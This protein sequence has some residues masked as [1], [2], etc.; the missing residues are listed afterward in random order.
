[1][2][3][4]KMMGSVLLVAGLAACGGGGGSPGTTNTSTTTTT[5]T[6]PVTTANSAVSSLLLASDKQQIP[7]D[8]ISPA[9]VVV[10]ALDAG[11]AR[12][13]NAVVNLTL[14]GGGILSTSSVTTGAGGTASFQLTARASDQ[15]NREIVVTASCE[16]CSA[17]ATTQSIKV[18]GASLNV[19]A[20]A[21]T[22]VIGGPP[23][24]IVV[25]VRDV[26]GNTMPDVPV[27]FASTDSSVLA[28]AASS[29]KTNASGVASVVV[30]AQGSGAAS[31]NISGLGEAKSL[32]FTVSS[33]TNALSFT[34]PAANSVA[35][36][37]TPQVIVVS[38]QG[39]SNV[40]FATTLGSFANG[41]SNQTV[42][43]NNGVAQAVLTSPLSGKATINAVDDISRSAALQLTISPPVSAANQIILTA[44][45][46]TIP[47]ST[48]T[49][50]SSI[51]VTARVQSSNGTTGQPV[52]NVPVVFS[53]TGGPN[54]GEY[55]TPALAK[56]DSTGV[57]TATFYAG[58]M[59]SIANGIEISAQIPNTSVETGVS[60]SSNDLL[61]T[62]G[63]QALSVAFGPGTRVQSSSDN[64]LY[65]LPYSVLVTDANN[66]P[67]AGAEV[68]LRMRPF[69][70]STG[71]SC[72]VQKT[73][74]SEDRN[75]NGSLDADEDGWRVLLSNN[76][77][78]ISSSMCS[79]ESVFIVDDK[80]KNLTPQNSD[81]G[82]VPRL[83][84][85]DSQ[86][87]ASFNLTYLKQS[88]LWVVPMLTATVASN[89]TESS[90]STIF[91]LRPSVEDA[92]DTTCFLPPSP[93]RE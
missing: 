52:A 44:I 25:T 93:Y 69:A 11:S 7:A 58:S 89:G 20:S 54:G 91:R 88:A 83:L 53:M 2:K 92:G 62:I 90:R 55:L 26:L 34:E 50:Q 73:F 43:V 28:V 15:T 63:G 12:V 77:S 46:T 39:A 19:T 47:I 65:L 22:L 79:S 42:A 30:S 49:T 45:R 6:S 80:D 21:S 35:L 14:V 87:V 17:P 51:V 38:A 32:A 10:S 66:N 85:T 31:L 9:T 56:S 60:P 78:A 3:L 41:S 71:S 48:T 16:A 27:L 23:G 13:P 81:A 82:G 29:V 74:C 37:N 24:S 68:T 61:L 4:L 64:T 5:T 84:T 1:M 72:S 57:A 70:F 67:V 33:G 59:A 8:S 18:I 36:I 76:D 40:T 86:G 75:A